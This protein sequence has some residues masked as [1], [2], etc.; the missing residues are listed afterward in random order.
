MK[1]ALL[2]LTPEE[3]SPV[4]FS[5]SEGVLEE[6]ELLLLESMLSELREADD[7]DSGAAR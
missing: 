6:E 7:P 1:L 2:A 5:T 4:E 3:L